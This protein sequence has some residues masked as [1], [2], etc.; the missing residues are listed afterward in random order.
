M[1][2]L[3]SIPAISGKKKKRFKKNCPVPSIPKP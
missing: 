3:S 1:K 2:R